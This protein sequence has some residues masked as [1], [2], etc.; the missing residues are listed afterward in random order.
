LVNAVLRFG[1]TRWMMEK[2]LGF[3]ADRT[4]P[5]Y[6]TQRFD[7]WFAKHKRSQNGTKATRGKVILWDDSW[8]RYNEPNIGQAAVKVLEAAG[9]EVVLEEKRKCCGR[10]ACSRGVLDEAKKAGEHNVAVFNEHSGSEPIIFLE[11]SCYTMFIDEYRQFEIPGAEKVAERCILFE[12]FM[13]ELLKREPDALPFKQ[14]GCMSIGIHGHCHAKALTDVSIVPKLVE[15]VPNSSARLLETGCCGM[16]GAFGMLKSKYELSLQ[17]A[18]QLLDRI[19]EL[20]QGSTLIASGT[21]CR[22]QITHL[23]D[24][25][26]L[27]MAEF[28]AKNLETV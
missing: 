7:K 15:N 12:E 8:V 26:P 3:A 24:H 17:V 6:T 13:Y 14:N 20:E 5:P 21:S 18:Q 22:H 4:F 23:T 28:L 10:P 19:N 25:E 16:A 11:P 27:H 1:L 2:T 9:F